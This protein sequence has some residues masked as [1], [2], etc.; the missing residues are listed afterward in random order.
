MKQ[1]WTQ[2]KKKGL[3]RV[4][5]CGFDFS[6]QMHSSDAHDNE[7]EVGLDGMEDDSL[8]IQSEYE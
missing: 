5:K 1:R 7:N 6:Q 8:Q 2:S 4:K 3:Q